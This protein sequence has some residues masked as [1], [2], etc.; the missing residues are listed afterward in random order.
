VFLIQ[1][2]GSPATAMGGAGSRRRQEREPL[3]VSVSLSE[4]SPLSPFSE[5]ASLQISTTPRRSR[6]EMV[7]G[8]YDSVAQ[9]PATDEGRQN[10]ACF[11]P[12]CFCWYKRL[13]ITKC[14]SHHICFQ[15]WTEYE[16]GLNTSGNPMVCPHCQTVGISE[17]ELELVDQSSCDLRNYLTTPKSQSPMSFA[18]ISPVRVGDSHETLVRKLRPFVLVPNSWSY[19][20]D[21]SGIVSEAIEAAM[22]RII[23]RSFD[24]VFTS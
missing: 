6:F 1:T 15:C 12:L 8:L 9:T 3:Q 21:A 4:S 19:S 22:Q 7:D 23:A 13:L 5:D 18:A 14:C 11:C 24:R 17:S 2:Q 20:A 10:Y 16:Q